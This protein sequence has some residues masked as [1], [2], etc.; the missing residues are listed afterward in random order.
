MKCRK[1]PAVLSKAFP[2]S[3]AVVLGGKLATTKNMPEAN[4]VCSYTH[5]WRL[6]S[7]CYRQRASTNS[8]A[9]TCI[10]TQASKQASESTASMTTPTHENTHRHRLTHKWTARHACR[11]AYATH[12]HTHAGLHTPHMHTH[13]HAGLHTPHMHTYAGQRRALNMNS[14]TD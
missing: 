1:I 7:G 13:T 9:L 11:P 12:T 5:S 14:D 3:I 4:C 8:R 10:H 6:F 2:I